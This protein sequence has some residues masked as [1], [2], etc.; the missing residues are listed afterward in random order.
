MSS[1]EHAHIKV[2]LYQFLCNPDY[3]T[4]NQL[5]MLAISRE[6]NNLGLCGPHVGY[7]SGEPTALLSYA[8]IRSCFKKAAASL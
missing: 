7:D 6:G 2:R 3:V 4:I 1:L 8:E 5:K